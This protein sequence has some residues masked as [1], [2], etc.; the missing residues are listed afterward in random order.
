M[1]GDTV[2]KG[3]DEDEIAVSRW[4]PHAPG[5]IDDSSRTRRLWRHGTAAVRGHG[6][7]PLD[8]S[9]VARHDQRASVRAPR[10]R[11]SKAIGIG[12]ERE[13]GLSGPVRMDHEVV[14]QVAETTI[15]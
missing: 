10:T 12:K 5:K 6:V 4:L 3:V 11:R 9:D 15:R 2:R 13:L 8:A 14:G 7:Q 1:N